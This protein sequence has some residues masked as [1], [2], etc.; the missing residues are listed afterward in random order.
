VTGG[1]PSV[2]FAQQPQQQLQRQSQQR[3]NVFQYFQEIFQESMR[4]G[5]SSVEPWLYVN[6]L[7]MSSRYD[8]I[9]IPSYLYDL[10]N[11]EYHIKIKY[12]NANYRNTLAAAGISTGGIIGP[13]G[14]GKGDIEGGTAGGGTGSRGGRGSSSKKP[15]ATST[16]SSV[17]TSQG[18]ITGGNSSSMGGGIGVGGEMAGDSSLK[19][20]II[21]VIPSSTMEGGGMNNRSYLTQTIAP[22]V[23]DPNNLNYKRNYDSLQSGGSSYYDQSGNS[24]NKRMKVGDSSYY[25]YNSSYNQQQSS[26]DNYGSSSSSLPQHTSI[27][28]MIIPST[29]SASSSSGGGYSFDLTQPNKLLLSDNITPN[30]NANMFTSNMSYDE[31][32]SMR[33]NDNKGPNYYQSAPKISG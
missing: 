9:K 13:I 27:G 23:Y 6:P 18:N 28:G 32:N 25:N 31:S 4:L 19:R 8:T 30:T 16:S 1:T 24:E 20:D 14:T 2:S 17:I 21:G 3:S 10:M 7:Q 29:T 15:R 26:S 33:V 5:V 22:Q 11:Q 12:M